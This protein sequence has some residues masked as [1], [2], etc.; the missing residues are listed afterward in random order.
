MR[1]ALDAAHLLMIEGG[2]DE[3]QLSH[4]SRESG[5]STGSLYHHFGSKE[6]I[7]IRLVEEFTESAK[8]DLAALSFESA[9]FDQRLALLL[10][11]T[12]K[13]FRDNSELYRSTAER[14]KTMPNIWAP[15]RQLRGAFE[16]RM[17]E[18]LADELVEMGVSAPD[19]AIHRMVQAVLGILTHSVVFGSGP[20]HVDADDLEAQIFTIGRAVLLLPEA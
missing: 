16:E 9:S 13:L 8:A 12:C 20:V 17:V 4:I 11:L 1:R 18:Q 3:V 7:I 2:F 15:L 14:V 5:V 6:G 19:A 10:D